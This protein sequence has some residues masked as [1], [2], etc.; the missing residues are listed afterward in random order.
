MSVWGIFI[1]SIFST[2]TA[3]AQDRFAKVQITT[4]AIA[5]NVY[6]LVGSG[7]NIGVSAGHDGILIIDDQYAPLAPKIQAA[8][9]ELSSTQNTDEIVPVKYVIN[10][11]F[12]GDHVG[13]NAHFHDNNGA[14]IFA[15]HNVRVRL[16]DNAALSQSSLPVVTYDNGISIHMNED[17]L[18]VMHFAGHTD[19]DSVVLFEEANVLHT[20]DLFFNGLFPYVDLDNG[21]NVQAYIDSV[22]AL[23][24]QIDEQTKIIPGHGPLATKADYQAFVSMMEATYNAVKSQKAQGMTLAEVLK[25]GVAEEYASYDWRFITEPRWLTTLYHSQ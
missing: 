10:T 15:H 11:H 25:V 7:G 8:L 16:L 21:G 20:G 17:K 22:N 2:N 24:T 3:F 14:T 4:Q 13:G 12:H 23:I 5:N 1:A 19:G 6:M 9:G 18:N